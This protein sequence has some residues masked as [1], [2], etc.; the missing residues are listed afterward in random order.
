MNIFRI[1]IRPRG[2]A[3]NNQLSVEHCLNNNIVGMGWNVEHGIKTWDDYSNAIIKL[4]RYNSKIPNSV[5][6]LYHNVK[7]NDAIW[8]RDTNG[9]YYLGRVISPWEYCSEP[10]Y[11]EADIVN[12]VRVDKWRKI[13]L[14]EVPG[15]LVASFR[16]SRVI[17]RAKAESIN[18]L[19]RKHLGEDIKLT[20]EQFFE[21]LDSD[22]IEDIVF[23]M[24]QKEGYI[25]IPSSRK[26][27]TMSYEF[28]A[29]DNNGE[30]IGAQVKTGW[31]E[32]DTL[33][34]HDFKKV[35]LYQEK[36]RIVNTDKVNN[37][38]KISKS[39]LWQIIE[40]YLDHLPGRIKVM[41]RL[42]S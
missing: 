25:I 38:H 36:N 28:F 16:P 2:G 19:T 39:E 1:H 6:F 5:K 29:L 11:L 37:I 42:V 3:A 21:A 23:I 33:K 20:K 9:M 40:E 10:N 30:K 14:D 17:Q 26:A 27:D 8:M 31:S 18:V 15:A 12:F 41:H 34:Y 7:E 32:I 22:D 24:L 35:Y 4:E 13:E